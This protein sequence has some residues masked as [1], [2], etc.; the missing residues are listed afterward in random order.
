MFAALELASIVLAVAATAFVIVLATRRVELARRARR[1][2]AAEQRLRPLAFA[3]LDGEEPDEEPSGADAEV[4]ASVL[5]R[6]A[7]RLS[8]EPRDHIARFFERGGHVEREVALLR[9]RR[10]ATRASAAFALGDMASPEA[11]PALLGALEDRNREVRAAAARSIG[12]LGAVAGVAPLVGALARGAVPR[13]IAGSALLGLGERAVPELLELSAAPDAGIRATAIELL[14]LLGDPTTA[15][16]LAPR[17]RDGSAE[18]RAKTARA[19]GRLGDDRAA[20]EL[21][22]VLR[23]RIPFVRAAAATGLMEIG[24]DEAALELMAMAAVDRFDPAHA[25]ARALSHLDPA[26]LP[27]LAS[28]PVASDHVREAADLA[29]MR[30]S[31]A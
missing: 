1:T 29:A 26:G 7:R 13:V 25:A 11:V 22:G 8:G 24:D 10:W 20:A 2:A 9:S 31:A 3:L 30:R 18:V 14:G 28:A 4:L 27:D 23:D 17:L 15:R 16:R 12:A 6:Y 5:A 19:L 21:R